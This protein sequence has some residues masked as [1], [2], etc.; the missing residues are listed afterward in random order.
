MVTTGSTAALLRAIEGVKQGW[1]PSSFEGFR[2][3]RE[4]DGTPSQDQASRLDR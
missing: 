2:E 3:L 4:N 1:W